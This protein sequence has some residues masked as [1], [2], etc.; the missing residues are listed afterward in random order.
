MRREGYIDSS[1]FRIGRSRL[2]KIDGK[3][4]ELNRETSIRRFQCDRR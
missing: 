1:A 2:A 3:M 4:T